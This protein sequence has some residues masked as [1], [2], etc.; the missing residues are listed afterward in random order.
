M[1]L[2]PRNMIALADKSLRDIAQSIAVP[3]NGQMLAALFSELPQLAQERIRRKLASAGIASAQASIDSG[4]FLAYSDSTDIR[5]LV[6]RHPELFF[7][8]KYWAQP[9]ATL[10]YG[11]PNVNAEARASVLERYDSYLADAVWL[12]SQTPRDLE[13]C[14]RDG[15]IRATLSVRLL[16]QDGNV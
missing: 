4:E 15:L 2:D 5:A 3:N 13:R 12:A 16:G 11:D 6:K 8:G 14:D 1:K 10:D 7:D 9:F